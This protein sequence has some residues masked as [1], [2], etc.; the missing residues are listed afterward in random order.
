MIFTASQL[1]MK[2]SPSSQNEIA[3][4]NCSPRKL[5]HQHSSSIGTSYQSKQNAWF[6]F[7]VSGVPKGNILRIQIANAS[8]HS[9]LYRY[10]MVRM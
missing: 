1:T 4:I 2:K 10:D 8:N 3:K 7:V 5:S 6:H 9:G